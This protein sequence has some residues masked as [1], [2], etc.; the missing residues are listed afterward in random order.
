MK[1]NITSHILIMLLMLAV[2]AACDKLPMNGD[3]DGQ[4][5]LVSEERDGQTTSLLQTRHYISFQLHTAQFST[6]SNP[7]CYYA[8]FR[9]ASD[10]L[11]FLTICTNSTNATWDDDNVPVSADS[12]SLLHPWGIYQLDPAFRV[13]TLNEH[14]LVLESDSSRL[15]FR[16]F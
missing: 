2:M 5:Q 9:H 11:Q 10:T 6:L 8:R 14:V 3:L 7:R 16:K 13:I 12:V 1:N 15:R 4:W